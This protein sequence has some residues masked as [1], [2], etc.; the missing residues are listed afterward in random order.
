[1]ENTIE[2]RINKYFKI[3][4]GEKKLLYDS[5]S[6]FGTVEEISNKLK[7]HQNRVN[8]ENSQY[9]NAE[10]KFENYVIREALKSIESRSN[11][12]IICFK[13]HVHKGTLDLQDDKIT[14]KELAELCMQELKSK[15]QSFS[16]LETF[17]ESFLDFKN[18]YDFI[19]DNT[20]ASILIKKDLLKELLEEL[21]I[22]YIDLYLND[23]NNKI[24]IVLQ[25]SAI[26]E[27]NISEFNSIENITKNLS[28]IIKAN[29]EISIAKKQER[30]NTYAS[31]VFGK[32]VT[33]NMDEVY[34]K[35]SE[36]RRVGK[37]CHSSSER[38]QTI[39]Q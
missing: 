8:N 20:N 32:E 27:L 30:I 17:I 16:N 33:D 34:G 1:M 14:L 26:I 38:K 35:R 23:K 5:F 11:N 24:S 36:E 19:K 2:E 29:E 15:K 37:E 31:F 13:I 3:V 10:K 25:N 18:K 7:L 9:F 12:E 6:M 28:K 22:E 39:L 4:F 21:N